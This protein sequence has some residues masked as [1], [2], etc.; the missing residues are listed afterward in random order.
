MVHYH[1]E[2]DL[3]Q[4]NFILQSASQVSLAELD[5][6]LEQWE[7]ED[8]L[9]AAEWAKLVEG[10]NTDVK[11]KNLQQQSLASRATSRAVNFKL[12]QVEVPT[13][14][15]ESS[16]S[17]RSLSHSHPYRT[18]LRQKHGSRQAQWPGQLSVMDIS[19]GFDSMQTAWFVTKYPELS[20]RFERIFPG[21][22][23]DADIYNKNWR[24]WQDLSGCQQRTAM[25]CSDCKW[26]RFARGYMD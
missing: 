15:S 19:L 4:S 18:S 1:Y 2:T 8:D 25:T 22:A 23:Y 3:A 26:R 14:V 13:S 6:R 17:K 10:L 16:R 20:A 9:Q 11:E 24:V 5:E 7:K 21:W 12:I